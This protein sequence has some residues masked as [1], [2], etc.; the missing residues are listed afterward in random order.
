MFVGPVHVSPVNPVL[1]QPLGMNGLFL[2]FFCIS[3]IHRNQVI[4]RRRGSPG[5][6]IT[7]LSRR[8]L[9]FGGRGVP[10][11]LSELEEVDRQIQ[12]RLDDEALVNAAQL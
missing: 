6:R 9:A 5:F 8:F 10:K 3:M 11:E 12:G 1:N 2:V 4:L 7:A